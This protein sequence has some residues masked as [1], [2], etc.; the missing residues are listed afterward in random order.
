MKRIGRY[1]ITGRLGRGGMSSVYKAKAPVTGR[2]V[3]VKI[4]DPRDEL[5]VDNQVWLAVQ[6]RF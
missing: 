3:A 4:L 2:V 5:F 6:F 1:E